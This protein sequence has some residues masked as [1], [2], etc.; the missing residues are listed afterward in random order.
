[1]IGMESTTE[2]SC[3]YNSLV[4]CDGRCVCNASDVPKVCE[5]VIVNTVMKEEQ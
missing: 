3:R 5:H 4:H 1:M 2:F